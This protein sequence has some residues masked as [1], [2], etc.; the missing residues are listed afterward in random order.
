MNNQ[1]N[2]SYK[3]L[4]TSDVDLLFA[5]VKE[6][7]SRKVDFVQ[8]VEILVR[9]ANRKRLGGGIEQIAELVVETNGPLPFGNVDTMPG[10]GRVDT[11]A[12]DDRVDYRGGGV[13][14]DRSIVDSYMNDSGIANTTPGGGNASNVFRAPHNVSSHMRTQ[15]GRMRKS[16]ASRLGKDKSVSSI[17]KTTPTPGFESSGVVVRGP[18]RFYYDQRTYTGTKRHGGDT[19]GPSTKGSGFGG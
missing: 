7:N 19:R 18:E 12:T 13:D 3:V 15:S 5:Q 6:R 1:S 16:V 14:T 10:P 11:S 8:F 17:D 4:K 9:I 2:V